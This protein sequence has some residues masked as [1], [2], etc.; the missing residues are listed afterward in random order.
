MSLGLVRIR[1][2]KLP[3]T[4]LRRSVDWYLALLDLEVAAEFS[5]QGVV[6]GAQLTAPDG[7]FAIALRER[8]FC[9]SEPD[10]AGFDAFALEAESVQALHDLAAR[11]ERLGVAC[12]GVQDRGEY[13]AS[14]DIPDPDGTVLRFL[15]NNVIVPG[16]FLG[17]DVDA[18]GQPSLYEK[19]RLKDPMTTPSES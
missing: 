12:G 18:S 10:L 19:P 7:G 3:V 14:L 6:R 4:D 5:E 15:A 16:R 17:L 8:A 13:G 2:A 9:A 1:H 11:C